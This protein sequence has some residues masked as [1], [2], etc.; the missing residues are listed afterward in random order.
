MPHAPDLVAAVDAWVSESV[1]AGEP[2][3][4]IEQHLRQF[5]GS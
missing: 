3:R 5:L 4:L 1:A 2:T